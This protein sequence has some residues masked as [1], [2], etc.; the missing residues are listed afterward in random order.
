MKPDG[1]AHPVR[2]LPS[3]ALPVRLGLFAA[4]LL[5]SALAGAQAIYRCG[6]DGRSYSQQ[7]CAEGVRIDADDTRSPQQ[8]DEARVR[9]ERLV[10][11][12]QALPERRPEAPRGA[13]IV[14]TRRPPPEPDSVLGSSPAYKVK[15]ARS[16]SAGK[17]GAKSGPMGKPAASSSGK[18][19]SPQK[20]RSAGG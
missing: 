3:V 20:R 5:L 4:G 11:E 10:R 12:A 1:S 9:G 19:D 17:K 18:A 2:R 7:P 16:G 14:H 6:P 15:G 8:Q 13:G